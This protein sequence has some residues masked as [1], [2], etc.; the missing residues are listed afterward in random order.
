MHFVSTCGFYYWKE[1]LEPWL[2]IC[3][4]WRLES[5]WWVRRTSVGVM[6][7]RQWQ[8]GLDPRL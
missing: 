7:R 5:P 2:F 6:E 3:V 8:T 4:L 1:T